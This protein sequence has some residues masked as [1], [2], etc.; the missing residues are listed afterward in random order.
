MRAVLFLFLFFW[1]TAVM[2]IEEPK[3]TVLRTTD[4]YEI[5]DYADRVAVETIQGD[6]ENGAFQR[7]F[8]YI[9]GA[10]VQSS[11]IAMTVP[12]TQST[13]IAMTAPVTQSTGK[14]GTAMRFFLPAS[15]T[16]DTAPV[17]SDDRVKLVLVRGGIYAV[18][19]YS[20]RSSVKNF[21]DAAQT[22]FDALRRDGLTAVGVP[23][24]ATYNGP[25][26]PFFLRRNEAMVRIDG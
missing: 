26:T 6:G 12:V 2:A 8:K 20:G 16:M 22:L 21:N 23:I 3:Y 4:L 24:K 10:N 17:P 1:G 11:K 5:R 14:D 7:L 15:Y 19:R 25:F 13:K 18:H 9:S